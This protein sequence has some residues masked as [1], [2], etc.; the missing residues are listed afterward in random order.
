MES[1]RKKWAPIRK[2]QAL[3]QEGRVLLDNRQGTPIKELDA[4]MS[5]E[6]RQL[7]GVQV[8]NGRKE[9]TGLGK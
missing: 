2:L 3:P 8:A 5:M 4:S 7:H 9:I 6:Q 1:V